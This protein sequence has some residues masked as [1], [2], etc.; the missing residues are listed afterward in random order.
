MDGLASH[1]SPDEFETSVDVI[2]RLTLILLHQDRA[3]LL[4][5][6]ILL[7]QQRKFL[8]FKFT[9]DVASA[10]KHGDSTFLTSSFSESCASSRCLAS[11]AFE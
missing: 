7:C 1:F 10:A 2:L 8:K 11:T 3:N 9:I 4:E 5:D 6:E